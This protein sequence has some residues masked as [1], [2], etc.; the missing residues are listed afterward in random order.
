MTDVFYN[1]V[2]AEYERELKKHMTEEAYGEF[3]ERVAKEGFRME[4]LGM[5]DG[6]FKNFCIDNIDFITGDV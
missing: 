3:A 4:V 5:A 1:F 2:I 6:D